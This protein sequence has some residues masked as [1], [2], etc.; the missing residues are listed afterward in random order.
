MNV[1]AQVDLHVYSPTAGLHT[2]PSL[3]LG[4]KES[5]RARSIIRH[6]PT[7]S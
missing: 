7:R 1:S 2:Q 5:V 3:P 4:V 6:I